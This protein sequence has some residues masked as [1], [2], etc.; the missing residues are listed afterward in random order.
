MSSLKEERILERRKPYYFQENHGKYGV[1]IT[2]VLDM[3]SILVNSKKL[4]HQLD[5]YIKEVPKNKSTTNESHYFF[6]ESILLVKH[7][8]KQKK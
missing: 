7:L 1:R 4:L 6:Y 2:K 8:R 3:K 5:L